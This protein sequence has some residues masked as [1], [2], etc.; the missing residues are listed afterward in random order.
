MD[1]S[2]L[3]AKANVCVMREN[4]SRCEPGGCNPI[5]Q[6]LDAYF[7]KQLPVLSA[8][9]CFLEVIVVDGRKRP[10]ETSILIEVLRFV[11]ICLIQ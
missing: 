9:R 1:C 10:S 4:S 2:A 5:L 11:V 6:I 7:A 3:W 8:E